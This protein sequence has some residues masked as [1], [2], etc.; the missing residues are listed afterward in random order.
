M[1]GM[2]RP[3]GHVPTMNPDRRVTRTR[4]PAFAAP[5]AA[6]RPAGPPPTTSTSV[7][8]ASSACRGG[9]SMWRGFSGR[10][11]GGI[12]RLASLQELDGDLDGLPRALLQLGGLFCELA[13]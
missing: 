2:A 1:T 7:S 13:L 6:P 3:G 9:N 10:F 4:A 5:S 12:D 8:P 11:R